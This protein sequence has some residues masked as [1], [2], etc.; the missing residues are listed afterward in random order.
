M[1]AYISAQQK[2]NTHSNSEEIYSFKS[3]I[4]NQPF[5]QTLK[6]HFIEKVTLLQSKMHSKML[7]GQETRAVMKGILALSIVDAFADDTT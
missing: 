4:K 1:H 7:C 6:S 3:H 2:Q 5:Y